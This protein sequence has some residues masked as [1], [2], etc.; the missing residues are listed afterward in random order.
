[1]ADNVMARRPYKSHTLVGVDLGRPGPTQPVHG[2]HHN[3]YLPVITYLITVHYTLFTIH[4]AFGGPI[5]YTLK[6]MGHAALDRV[7]QGRPLH[8]V[9]SNKDV[10][11]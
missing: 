11:R 3:T 5:H 9:R 4:S 6:L 1:M 8:R 10:V 7:G 2:P